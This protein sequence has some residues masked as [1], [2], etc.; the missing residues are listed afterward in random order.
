MY[1][2]EGVILFIIFYLEQVYIW[3]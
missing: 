2:I 1:A 3:V